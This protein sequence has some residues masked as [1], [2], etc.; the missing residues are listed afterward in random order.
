MSEE[1]F[2]LNNWIRE[3]KIA[4]QV[5]EFYISGDIEEPECYID[6]FDII[7][8]CRHDDVV[9]LYINSCGGNLFTGIQFLRVLSE[10]NA[11]VVVSIEGA[12]MSAATLLFLSAD[13]VEITPHSSIMI[14]NYSGGTFGK[15]NEMHLQIQHER[16]WAETLFRDVYEDFLTV[17][18]IQSVI[19]GKDIWLDSD[20]VMERMQKRADIRKELALLEEA[21]KP[22]KDEDGE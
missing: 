1:K 17:D 12:C 19:D 11:L 14:H 18:E 2:I 7:R 20:D 16:K 10:T 21:T 8:H 4:A 15:G 5:F 9:K 6:M 3:P 13:Q 22:E